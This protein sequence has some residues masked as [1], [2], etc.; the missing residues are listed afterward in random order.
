MWPSGVAG[1]TASGANIRLPAD[2]DDLAA[3]ETAQKARRC[4]DDCSFLFCRDPR[5]GN[6]WMLSSA[7]IAGDNGVGSSHEVDT[8]R[9]HVPRWQP[10]SGC[11]LDARGDPDAQ[12]RS[13]STRNASARRCRSCRRLPRRARYSVN[14]REALLSWRHFRESRGHARAEGIGGLQNALTC[15]GDG[16][17]P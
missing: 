3:C 17:T 10:D 1:L 12:I 4:T 2:K 11:A 13:G 14:R 16:P 8:D 7:K 6:R 15:R 5:T 9:S